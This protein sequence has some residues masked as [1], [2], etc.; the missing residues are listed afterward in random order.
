[1]HPTHVDHHIPNVLFHV[2]GTNLVNKLTKERV[3]EDIGLD[4]H[5]VAVKQLANVDK[6]EVFAGDCGN[7]FIFIFFV[8]LGL[9]LI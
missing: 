2:V 3:V 6:V 5:E 1:M 4:E 8:L 9:L 7:F